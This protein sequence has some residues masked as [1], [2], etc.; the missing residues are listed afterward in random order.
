MKILFITTYPLEYN[1]SANVRNMG[2]IFG[3]YKNGNDIYTYSS[4]P[5]D[6]N[7]YNGELL[8]F[9]FKDR[10]WID[11]IK[12][13]T[14][15]NTPTNK[16]G[17]IKTLLYRFYNYFSIYDRR[18]SLVKYIDSKKINIEFDLIIS[19]SD[20][21]SAHLFAERLISQNKNICKNWI[22]YWGDPFTNDISTNH[23]FGKSLVKKEEKRIL[24]KADKIVYVSPF[25]A[26][27][28]K[29]KYPCLNDKIFFLPISY[30]ESSEVSG[31]KSIFEQKNY[32][33]VGY[34]GDY[35]S[36][37]RN[38]LPLVNV[39]NK[40]KF[41]SVIIGNSDIQITSTDYLKVKSRVLP[42]ELKELTDKIDVYICLCNLKGTQIPGKVYHYVNSGKPIIIIVDGDYSKKLRK[43]FSSFN[44]F[45]I[46]ENNESDIKD[47]LIRVMKE[48]RYFDTPNELN[49]QH[50][51]EHFILLPH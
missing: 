19:S 39:L 23:L 31:S 6:T 32:K 4:Y 34:L 47:C 10:Y 7:Y 36:N 28:I 18:S 37:N 9:P 13:V 38:I 40:E 30:I 22:Q 44:R 2:L 48:N 25:T 29:I 8:K 26:D 15:G 45:Y 46:C 3:L 33:M 12:K 5:T 17:K 21:K 11:G 43:Y 27:D 42:S 20:A 24:S 1:T 35:N 14:K 16:F 41:N 49:P 50:I 51:A